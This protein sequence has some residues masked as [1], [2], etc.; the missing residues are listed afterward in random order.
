[1]EGNNTGLFKKLDTCALCSF[2][3]KGFCAK[4]HQATFENGFC[5]C[6]KRSKLKGDNHGEA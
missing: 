4:Y 2:W 3:F 1:M 5:E 6:F